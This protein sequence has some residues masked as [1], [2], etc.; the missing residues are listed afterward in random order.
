MAPVQTEEMVSK[1]SFHPIY[2]LP[3]QRT[4]KEA[5]CLRQAIQQI[6]RVSC[7][8]IVTIVLR[9]GAQVTLAS[10]MLSR[11]EGVTSWYIP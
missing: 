4:M 3:H 5:G 10:D 1:R 6:Q 7:G 8:N 2:S 11:T 9:E